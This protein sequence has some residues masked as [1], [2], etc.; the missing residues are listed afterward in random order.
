MSSTLRPRVELEVVL[1]VEPGALE[2]AKEKVRPPRKSKRVDH[3][4]L[5]GGPFPAAFGL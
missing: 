2:V 3:Q 1:V 4:L 5:E